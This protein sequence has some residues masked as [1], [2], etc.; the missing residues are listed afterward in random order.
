MKKVVSLLDLKVM[1]NGNDCEIVCD[2]VN[3]ANVALHVGLY[4]TKNGPYGW[5][6]VVKFSRMRNH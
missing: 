5:G 6:N 1:K 2:S 4:I 3:R